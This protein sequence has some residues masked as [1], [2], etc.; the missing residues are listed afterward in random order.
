MKSAT[1]VI[2]YLMK[3]Q[4]MSF[5]SAL[6]FTKAKRKSV[7]P[8]LGFERQLKKYENHLRQNPMDYSKKKNYSFPM[9][10]KSEKKKE[11]LKGKISL[12]NSRYQ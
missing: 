2:A 12:A 5:S 6:K 11:E 7:C 10:R 8:N 9:I 3:F 1:L 4:E